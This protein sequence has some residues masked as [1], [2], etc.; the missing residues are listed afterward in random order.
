MFLQIISAK[1]ALDKDNRPV[2][3]NKRLFLVGV[4]Q[5]FVYYNLFQTNTLQ[6][7]IVTKCIFIKYCIIVLH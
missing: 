5:I 4:K 7:N 1:R 6:V 2:L 3:D